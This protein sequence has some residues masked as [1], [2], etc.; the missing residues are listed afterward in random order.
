MPLSSAQTDP[1]PA[2]AA[3]PRRAAPRPVRQRG[4]AVA[5][6]MLV[7]LGIM[8]VILVGIVAVPQGGSS[9]TGGDLPSTTVNALQMTEKRRTAAAAAELA[10]SGVELTVQWLDAQPVPPP[11]TTAFAPALW[12]ATLAGS[13]ARA[14]LPFP[15]P[16]DPSSTFSILIYPDAGNAAAAQKKYLI[17]S[18]GTSGAAVQI[19]RAYVQQVSYAKFGYFSDNSAPDAC[20]TSGLTSFDGPVHCN[21]S[22]GT[23]NSIVWKSGSAAPLFLDTDPDAVTLSGPAVHWFLNT[24]QTALAPQTTGDWLSLAAGG[25][26]SVHT[27][28]PVIPFPVSSAA[29]MQAAL[30]GQPVPTQTGVFLPSV[31]GSVS[32]GVL[33]GAATAGG[34][35]IHGDVSQMTLGVSA[36]TTQT[37]TISQTDQNGQPL[38]TVVTLIPTQN[39]TTVLTTRF[40]NLVPVQSLT[41]YSGTTNGVVYCDGSIGSQS[42]PKS[43]GLAGVIADNQV[44]NLGSVLSQSRLTIATAAGRNINIDGS[45]TYNTARVLGN[46]G[47]PLPEALDPVFG[48]KAGTLGLISQDIEVVDTSNL[49]LPITN[50]EV[51]A[52]ALAFDTFDVA[53]A[54]TRPTGKFSFLGSFLVEHG[55]AFGR[56]DSAANLQAGLSTQRFYDGRLAVNPPPA[57]PAASHLYDILSW[58]AV[59][60]CL[61]N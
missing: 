35:Y 44:S 8:T 43:G 6:S 18:V 47:V 23:P 16:S 5:L 49:G 2:D 12:G 36:G 7:L 37:I 4:M 22:D 13:P 30:A 38:S 56:L 45:L 55:G 20:W 52:A 59:P 57:F 11:Q 51:D 25:Q 29:Q 21:N 3:G 28:T 48:T 61:E 40:Q 10:A 32:L 26:G 14:V 46:N 1:A 39:Q 9:R 24:P 27:G 19:V 54:N 58:S 50:I 33:T 42:I 53:N 60:Q 31:G 34:V 17:E 15:D 41:T